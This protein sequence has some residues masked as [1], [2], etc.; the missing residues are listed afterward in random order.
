MSITRCTFIGHKWERRRY[1]EAPPDDQEAT[2]A[3]CQRCGKRRDVEVGPGILRY[4]AGG[5][6]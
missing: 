1:P 6:F 5:Q 4:T 2:F 3:E